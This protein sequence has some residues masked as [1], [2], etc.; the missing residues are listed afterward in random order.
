MTTRHTLYEHGISPFPGFFVEGAPVSGG[1]GT[2]YGLR[3]CECG[4]VIPHPEEN[5]LLTTEEHQKSM[6]EA[7]AKN[8]RP[9]TFLFL[10]SKAL[11][12]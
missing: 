9:G 3:G 10:E 5:F 7:V 1:G 11:D 6:I 2:D 8:R 12:P 4:A